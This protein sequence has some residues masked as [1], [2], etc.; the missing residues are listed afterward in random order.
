MDKILDLVLHTIG[1]ILLGWSL[2]H[3]GYIPLRCDHLDSK[4]YC[5]IKED[6]SKIVRKKVHE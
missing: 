1:G 5:V 2:T 4:G 6:V 3:W